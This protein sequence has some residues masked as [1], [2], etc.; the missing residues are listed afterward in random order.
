MLTAKCGNPAEPILKLTLS[1]TQTQNKKVKVHTFT[2][3]TNPYKEDPS[4]LAQE[5]LVSV[6]QLAQR[7]ENLESTFSGIIQQNIESSGK[8][9][10]NLTL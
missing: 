6:L 3:E 7:Y 1:I 9:M 4:N 2:I 8:F 10:P 5:V